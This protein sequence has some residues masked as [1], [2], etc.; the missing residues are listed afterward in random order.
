MTS[1]NTQLR[2]MNGALGARIE[3]ID[4]NAGL[5]TSD[6][7][8]IEAAL[9][10][11]HAVCIPAADMSP[12]QH[13]QIARH[14]GEPE[15][16]EFFPNLGP[17]LEHVTVLDSAAGERAD[18]WHSDEQFLPTPPT[19]TFTHAQILP[20]FGGETGFISLCAA[21]DALSTGMKAYL[22]ELEAVHDYAMIMEVARQYGLAK[23]EDIANTLNAN[24]SSA[25]P[26]VGSHGPSGRKTLFA[27]P[28][29]TRFVQGVPP[30]ESRTILS[31][32]YEHFQKPEFQYRHR[33]QAGD[34]MMWDNRCTLH[35]ALNDY[36]QRRLMHRVSVLPRPS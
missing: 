27:S 12:Q 2:K 23:P 24:K 15:H 14:F 7:E 28:T 34:M 35:Y 22:G 33:W 29:Y 25:H 9:A 8:A 26:L 11:H 30:L 16:H 31:F 20:P 21:Y 3:G 36:D 13:L 1:A 5:K 19:F 18:M 4:F 10:E 6:L 17:G 32:L